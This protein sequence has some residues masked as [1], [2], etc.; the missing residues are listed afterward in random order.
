MEVCYEMEGESIDVNVKRFKNNVSSLGS[1]DEAFTLL[2]HF[3]YLSWDEEGCIAKIPN[4]EIYG[5]F[6]DTVTRMNDSETT[7]RVE[8][9]RNFIKGLIHCDNTI[10]AQII[11]EIH[12]EYQE[13]KSVSLSSSLN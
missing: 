3:G 5:E 11:E 6:A 1:S 10:V 13:V 2:I 12:E 9:S 8:K 7:K 4:K